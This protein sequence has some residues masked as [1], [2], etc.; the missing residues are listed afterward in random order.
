MPSKERKLVV[1]NTLANMDVCVVGGGLSGLCAA[2]A[3]AREGART[4]LV[5]DRP[6]LGGCA[7]TEIRIP[8]SGAGHFNPWA[9]ET[10]II[11]E[12]LTEERAHNHDRAD[13][14][15]VNAQWDIVLYDTVRRQEN[16]TV[17]MNTHVVDVNREAR[18]I[19][20]V[21]GPQLGTEKVWEVEAQIFIDA[22]GDGTVGARA[23]VPFR[24]GQEA[25]SEYGE[26][27]AP[28]E[29]WDWT[30]G[31][32]L[33]FRA[34]DVGRPV[35]FTPPSWAEVYPDEDSLLHRTHS[36]VECG[37]WWIEVGHPYHTI[38]ENEEIRDELMRHVLGVWD[39]IKNRCVNKEA[40]ANYT[41]E[42]VGFVPAKR[43]SRR[44][45]GT[46]VMTQEEI[47][48]R[49]LYPDRVAYGGWI[50]DDHTK[51]GILAR[52]EGPNPHGHVS[53]TPYLVSP[54]SVTLRSLYAPEVSNLYFAGRVMSASRVVFNSLRVQR[55]LA[56]IGQAAGT[57][58]AQSVRV[59]RM[60][61]TF[62]SED[63][64]RIQQSLLRQDCYVPHLRNEDPDDVARTAKVKASSAAALI[65]RPRET[66]VLLN[67]RYAQVL[68]LSDWP[69]RLRIFVR[70][71]SGE[72][73]KVRAALHKAFDIWDL[74][75]LSAG[76]CASVEWIVPPSHEGAIESDRVGAA[77]EPGLYW[78]CVEPVQNVTWLHGE[79][80]PGLTAAKHADDGWGML[81]GTTAL[82]AD[83]IPQ[84]RP[85]EPQNVVNGVSRPEAWP[86]VW[87]S[88]DGL[89]LW[90]EIELAQA[91]ELSEIR[92]TW[93]LNLCR[94]W[95]QMGPFFRAPELARDYR[96]EVELDDGRILPWADV[97]G[98]YHRLRVHERP[99]GLRGS[100]RTLRVT[101]EATNGAPYV[102]LAEVRAYC[103]SLA[104]TRPTCLS[105]N[106]RNPRT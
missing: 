24:I 26:P 86:N 41:L 56:V 98:N 1:T 84:S 4:A 38:K 64:H 12:L 42:W 79:P 13:T 99:E 25:R 11:M 8:P 29:A 101:V 60:P 50:I 62:H 104:E 69:E 78:L 95:P 19:V 2:L 80:L 63:I 53:W 35:P 45:V 49:Q 10:G 68:P 77:G 36:R 9:N 28:P 17:L 22:S 87:R 51:G 52:D 59:K 6:V 5:H 96:I 46:H 93:G 61:A 43:E 89:P 3:A 97:R 32:S 103:P 18:R 74:A 76:G 92:V 39:H 67:R 21:V 40:A 75:S 44:F 83:A 55:T 15:M 90:C 72:K 105:K 82:A 27:L 106:S 16:L 34:R 88:R 73:Q 85:F 71:T 65:A 20:S 31:S 30:L 70:N 48:A 66:G 54:Y 58:A 7:S 102:E 23:G 57:A 100:I 37:Y 94:T 91:T 14:G 33:M 47:Q 81:A